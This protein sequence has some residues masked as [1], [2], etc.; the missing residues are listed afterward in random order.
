MS[1]VSIQGDASGT[2]T[3]TIAAPNTNSNYTL[4]LPEATGTMLTSAGGQTITKSADTVQTLNR[5]TSDGTIAEFQKDGT[6]VGSIGATSGS[7]GVGQAS[8]G[9]GFFNTDNIVFPATAAGAVRDDAIKLGY[10][11]GRFKDL[12]LSGNAQL[13]NGYNLSW[14]GSYSSGYPTV[15]ATNSSGGYIAFAPNGNAPSANQ[16]RI[17]GDGIE[18]GAASSN[19]NDYEEGTWTPVILM[20]SGTST[21][22]A[23]GRYVKTGMTVYATFYAQF[24]A[25]ASSPTVNSVANFPFVQENS[26]TWAGVGSVR[27]NSQTGYQW[28]VRMNNNSTN[29]LLRRYDNQS[30]VA[31]NYVFIGSITYTTP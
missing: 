27:E 12:Y 23:Y 19:L 28:H 11:G 8:T 5:T 16:V 3:L 30:S 31:V 26:G 24:T 25:A 14:G 20:D 9:L 7:L 13:G 15:Y 21:V 22:S 6:T 17:V 10:S 29:A 2:G 18:F 1:K 4:T